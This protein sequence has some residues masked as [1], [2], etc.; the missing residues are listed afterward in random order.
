[1]KK[2]IS[3]ALIAD[4]LLDHANGKIMDPTISLT[5]TDKLMSVGIDSHNLIEMIIFLERQFGIKIPDH[6][7]TIGNLNSIES[8]ANCA[9]E[10][11]KLANAG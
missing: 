11:H 7:L 2:E 8:L 1:M 3:P 9:F 4:A 5:K 6:D 10:N